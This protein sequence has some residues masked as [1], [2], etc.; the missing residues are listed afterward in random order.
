VCVRHADGTIVQEGMIAA[1]REA[2]DHWR[3]RLPQ[4]WIGLEADDVHRLDL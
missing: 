2:V 3:Q 4:P 1:N